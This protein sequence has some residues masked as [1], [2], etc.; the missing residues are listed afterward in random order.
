MPITIGDGTGGLQGDPVAVAATTLA[1]EPL[2][3]ITTSAASNNV[4]LFTPSTVALSSG[5][6]QQVV[7]AAATATTTILC[8]FGRSGFDSRAGHHRYQH[9]QPSDLFSISAGG[10]LTLQS[11]A[12]AASAPESAAVTTLSQ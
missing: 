3:Y 12:T 10:G 11:Q 8:P 9:Q 4:G 7:T 2:A 5:S 6:P 1:G